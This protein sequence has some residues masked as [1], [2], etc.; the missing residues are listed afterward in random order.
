MKSILF[1]KQEKKA[2]SLNKSEIESD[3]EKENKRNKSAKYMKSPEMGTDQSKKHHNSLLGIYEHE[4]KDKEE[5]E[6][7]LGDL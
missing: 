2:E 4:E 7:Q 5:K 1:Q 6:R 3:H